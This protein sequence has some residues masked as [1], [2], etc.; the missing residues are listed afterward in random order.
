MELVEFKNGH[1][2][3]VHEHIAITKVKEFLNNHDISKDKGGIHKI[4]TD[5]FYNIIDM[6]T[7]TEE[8]RPWES[9][10]EYYDVHYLLNG[11]ETILYNFLSQMELSEY[12]VDDD[13]QQMNGEA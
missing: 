10:K 8:N 3:T 11:E 5:F 9:H 1:V 12:K 7:T 4:S 2:N 6:E 13:W